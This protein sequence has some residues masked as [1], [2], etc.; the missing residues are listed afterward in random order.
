MRTFLG[1]PVTMLDIG[2]FILSP[3]LSIWQAW[4]LS[5]ILLGIVQLATVKP[6]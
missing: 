3:Y 6:L 1:K 4:F 5:A 2:R